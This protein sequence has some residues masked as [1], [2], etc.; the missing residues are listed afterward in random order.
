M[1]TIV[2]NCHKFASAAQVQNPSPALERNSDIR[3]WR[4][5]RYRSGRASPGMRCALLAWV[6]TGSPSSPCHGSPAQYH[7]GHDRTVGTRGPG[8]LREILPAQGVPAAQGQ[9]LSGYEKAVMKA[10]G[11]ERLKPDADSVPWACETTRDETRH[12]RFGAGKPGVDQRRVET[13]KRRE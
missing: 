6:T 4:R 12:R 7:R 2:S 8:R 1:F 3:W 10:F 9:G 5:R 11:I 13:R